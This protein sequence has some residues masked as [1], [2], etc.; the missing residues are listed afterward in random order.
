MGVD[1][2]G[3]EVHLIQFV[4][5]PE[6]IHLH[7]AVSEQIR[8]GN[9]AAGT[10]DALKAALRA[11]PFVGNSVVCS[12]RSEEVA[13]RPLTMPAGV[14]PDHE[15]DFR[16]ALELEARPVLPY[17]PENAKMDYLPLAPQ[18]KEGTERFSLLLIAIKEED[19]NRHLAL[20]KAAGLRCLHLEVGPCAITRMFSREEQAYC[21]ISV[22]TDCTEVSIATGENLLFSR[23]IRVGAKH[24]SDQ[25]VRALDV[26]EAEAN[27]LLRVYGG[28]TGQAA[29]CD[30]ENV[31]ETGVMD[32]EV[33]LATVFEICSS[34]YETFVTELRRSVDYFSRQRGQN[35]VEK[36]YL[37]GTN[38]PGGMAEF[39]TDRLGLSVSVVDVFE[40]LQIRGGEAVDRNGEY[41]VAAGLALSQE[42]GRK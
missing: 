14:T 7:A 21:V 3:S 6:G 40:R 35:P 31:A 9:G 5:T 22:D 37:L 1:I 16:A 13:I 33:L 26:G 27:Y 2:R 32:T 11:R 8:G 38:I 36:A 41:R 17:G 19:V 25:L 18:M 29:R 24:L 42:A 28:S 30:Y 15:E 34:T 4:V 12:L 39:L 10:L 20:L 23:T